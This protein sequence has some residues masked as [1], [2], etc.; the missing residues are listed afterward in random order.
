MEIVVAWWSWCEEGNTVSNI[1]HIT[2]CG[3]MHPY[4]KKQFAADTVFLSWKMLFWAMSQ[5]LNCS[6]CSSPRLTGAKHFWQPQVGA[7]LLLKT[8]EAIVVCKL[9]NSYISIIQR[10][11]WIYQQ[12]AEYNPLSVLLFPFVHI[13]VSSF[14]CCSLL[15][16]SQLNGCWVY[17]PFCALSLSH[18]K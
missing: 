4:S 14:R 16:C 5:Q 3:R 9:N 12:S 8:L 18:G 7:L 10:I 15:H 11:R 2:I 13:F 17:K 1:L 6:H